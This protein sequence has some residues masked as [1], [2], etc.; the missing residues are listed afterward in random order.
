M[1]RSL[2]YFFSILLVFSFLLPLSAQRNRGKNPFI[3]ELNDVRELQE[4]IQKAKKAKTRAKYELKLKLAQK[5]LAAA[6]KKEL[7]VLDEYIKKEED[8]MKPYK[9]NIE[10]L[11]A[12]K[13]RLED[14]AGLK[15]E[16]GGKKTPPENVKTPGGGAEDGIAEDLSGKEDK[17]KE[18]KASRKKRKEKKNKKK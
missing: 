2:I 13:K 5:E 6:L 7:D 16:P 8:K 14:L 9:K 17:E 10:K 12:E 4:K 15:K 3:K 18:K 1:K 11:Q